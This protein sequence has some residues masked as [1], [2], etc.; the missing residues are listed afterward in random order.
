MELLKVDRYD[1][2]YA[3]QITLPR[4]CFCKHKKNILDFLLQYLD[5][6]MYKEFNVQ[7]IR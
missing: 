3:A 4:R 5:N 7:N 1:L 6:N 2:L